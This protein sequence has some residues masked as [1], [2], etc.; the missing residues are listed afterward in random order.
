[1]TAAAF[2]TLVLA[3]TVAACGS[4]SS[5]SRPDA[6][7]L[8]SNV[9]QDC[10]AVADVLA[11]GPDSGADPVGYAQAQILPLRKL[12]IA[13]T[14]LHRDVLALADAY[15]AFSTGS[16]PGAAA[17]ALKVSKAEKAVNSICPQAAS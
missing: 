7:I 17:A 12:T 16:H 9:Q 15:Q 5:S 6:A 13:D 8:G 3:M 14:A 11:D 1:V 4:S 2:L 10:T